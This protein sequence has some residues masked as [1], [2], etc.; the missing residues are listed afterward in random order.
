MVNDNYSNL[1]LITEGEANGRDDSDGFV[2]YIDLD[3]EKVV[4]DFWTTR[5]YCPCPVRKSR[6]FS[7]LTAEEQ[8]KCAEIAKKHLMDK[9]AKEIGASISLGE[10]PNDAKYNVKCEVIGGRKYKGTGRLVLVRTKYWKGNPSAK[11]AVIETSPETY[12]SVN[13]KFV[14]LYPDY[15]TAVSRKWKDMLYDDGFNSLPM[16]YSSH[17]SFMERVI[18]S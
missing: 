3:A 18:M 12:E 5:A 1:V 9:F 17:P 4:V 10:W 6:K 7:E 8:K 11:E 14:K 2:T 16:C 13:P 15:E